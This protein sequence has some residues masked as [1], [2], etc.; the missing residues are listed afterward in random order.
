MDTT[1]TDI[2]AHLDRLERLLVEAITP[3]KPGLTVKE[4]SKQSGLS[5][6]TVFRRLEAGTIRKEK[7]RIPHSELRKYLS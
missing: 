1:L 2:K 4:F 3:K 7:G 6:T 5:R